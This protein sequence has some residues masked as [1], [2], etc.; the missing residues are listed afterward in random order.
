MGVALPTGLEKEVNIVAALAVIHH[1]LAVDLHPVLF[2]AAA[3]G[4]ADDI[5]RADKKYGFV[6]KGQ[7]FYALVI[8]GGVVAHGAAVVVIIQADVGHGQRSLRIEG[9]DPQGLPAAHGIKAE[10]DHLGIRKINGVAHGFSR[11]IEQDDAVHAAGLAGAQHGAVVGAAGNG[12]DGARKVQHII[13]LQLK[14]GACIYRRHGGGYVKSVYG[15]RELRLGHP[16]A[17]QLVL[18]EPRVGSIGKIPAGN[19]IVVPR[20]NVD[21]FIGEAVIFLGKKQIQQGKA[22]ANEHNGQACCQYQP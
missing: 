12:A 3:L 5:L 21:L 9:D 1:F 13:I 7:L 2:P 6:R 17:L 10:A 20:L 16:A 4:V 18:D 14:G 15:R 11:G 19:H 22:P 8:E